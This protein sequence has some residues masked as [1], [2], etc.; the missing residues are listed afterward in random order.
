M[1]YVYFSLTCLFDLW[2]ADVHLHL[3][4]L[5]SI[6]FAGVVVS[7]QIYLFMRLLEFSFLQR[8]SIVIYFLWLVRL[9][10]TEV[11]R[12]ALDKMIHLSFYIFEV[13]SLLNFWFFRSR[14]GHYEWTFQGLL[15]LRDNFVILEHK[16]LSN[17]NN[18]YWI[19]SMCIVLS[20]IF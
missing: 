16:V 2:F 11:G 19:R 10:L 14:Y 9:Q 18:L 12:K 17:H 4:L 3:S 20:T 8:K 7:A 13:E 5:E 15:Y 1:G 6:A